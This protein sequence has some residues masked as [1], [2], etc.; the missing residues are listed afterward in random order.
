[1]HAR[2]HH[3]P[4]PCP[5]AADISAP[6]GHRFPSDEWM[7]HAKEALFDLSPTRTFTFE[8]FD[9]DDGQGL[10]LNWTSSY[11]GTEYVC[12]VSLPLAPDS[13]RLVS[14]MLVQLCHSYKVMQVRAED[15]D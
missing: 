13:G 5:S 15:P 11:Q 12:G 2:A 3:S 7:L 6:R 4:A 9:L 8:S 10:R 1:M 14:G